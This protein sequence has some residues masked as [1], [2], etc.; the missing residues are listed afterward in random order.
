MNLITKVDVAKDCDSD[1]V[2]LKRPTSFLE[3]VQAESSS[4]DPLRSRHSST[5]CAVVNCH[6]QQFDQ[7]AQ[8]LTQIEHSSVNGT[9]LQ[10]IRGC[11]TSGGSQWIISAAQ[12]D[13]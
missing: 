7:V 11:M 12:V 1:S 4:L 9:L 5:C 10:V 2:R 8:A 3:V 13:V 6:S